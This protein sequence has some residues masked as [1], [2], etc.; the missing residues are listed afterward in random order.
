MSFWE[1]LDALDREAFLAINGAHAPWADALMETMSNML[2]WFPLY[3]VLLFMLRRRFGWKGLAWSALLIAAMVLCS[4][5][6][7][8]LLF[9]ETVMRLRPCHEPALQGLVHLSYS[10]CG[11]NYGFVSS[12][13]SNHFAIAIFM[14]G[15]L[16]GRPRW[17]AYALL[18]W[19]VL[20]GYSRVYLGVHYPGDVLV[21]GLYGSLIGAIFATLHRP[22]MARMA[23][24]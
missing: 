4:D 21:G 17:A 23:T 18:A 16:Q 12:H 3:L 2:V 14:I 15:A 7:S 8:V 24:R 1:R 5:K 19:A 9:K 20:I 6:G 22:L 10:G 11:G 13:A